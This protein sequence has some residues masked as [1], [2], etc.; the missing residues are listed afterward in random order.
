MSRHAAAWLVALLALPVAAAETA[1]YDPLAYAR[2]QSG[3]IANREAVIP[4]Q[5]YTKTDG[6]ANPCWTCHTQ[7]NGHNQ[8]DD[9]VLQLAYAFSEVGLTNHWQNLFL[10]VEESPP[11]AAEVRRYV[12]QDNYT[13][14]RKALSYSTSLVW[15]PDIDIH[16]GFDDEGFARDGSS[17]RALRFKP[18][19]GTFW[20]TNGNTDDV[21]IR[22]PWQ[23]RRD[24]EGRE[25]RDIYKANLALIEAA[26]TTPS[27]PMLQSQGRQVESLDEEALHWDLDGDGEARGMVQRIRRLPP[28]F[29]GSASSVPL[30]W[31][32]YP[33]GTEFLHT[34]R[35]LDPGAPGF[36]SRRMKELRYSVKSRNIGQVSSGRAYR[37]EKFHKE[38]GVLPLFEGTPETGYVNDFGWK[39][40]GYIEDAQ[41]RL[42]LQSQEEH[43]YC[44]GCHGTIGVTAD[45]TF[46]LPRK[47][48]GRAGWQPQSLVGQ[49]DLP[50][51][52]HAEPE[53]LTYFQRVGGGDEFR[54]NQEI[55]ERF[56]SG[57]KPRRELVLSA[58]ASG[59]HDLAWLLY[60]GA[61]RALALNRAY[62]RLVRRQR[63]D[64]GRDAVLKPADKVHRSIKNGSTGFSEAQ[65]YRDGSLW[66][67]WE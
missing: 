53:A 57:G 47:L 1:S 40:Q 17:W 37:G 6:V 51:W 15:T 23:F 27:V 25:S 28:G 65:V 39:L 43:Y 67:A 41:G 55:L 36:M 4:V 48:P 19:P 13:P 24:A 52:G 10:P 61:D 32:R 29:F 45:Q 58:S 3:K 26:M 66:L 59:E 34:V 33:A 8:M 62:M 2:A 54:A 31:G 42:R 22:L 35:Y 38:A 7:Q 21:M 18:F 14:L 16:A 56:F 50:Q 5:C 64:L 63:F 30:E 46:A 49:K 44:M 60:P 9:W 20:P 11:S 12:R